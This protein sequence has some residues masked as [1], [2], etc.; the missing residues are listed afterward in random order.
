L[1]EIA[2]VWLAIC[3]V[4][5]MDDT[6]IVDTEQEIDEARDLYVALAD[7]LNCRQNEQ[8]S[9]PP[10]WQKGGAVAGSCLGPCL[11]LPQ[12]NSELD[13]GILCRLHLPE[14]KASKYKDGL[15]KHLGAE[16]LAPGA[17]GK[18]A[19]RF[20]WAASV[21]FGR[22]ARAFLWPVRDR[23]HNGGGTVL[24]S[25]ALRAALLALK[26]FVLNLKGLTLYASEAPRQ[27]VVGFV[28]ASRSH[29]A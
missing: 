22:S 2:N 21:A 8:K 16:E 26:G 28:D 25:P 10:R 23:Q 11:S 1:L 7:L 20:D 9:M 4:V 24:L 17:A 15:N 5:H 19:G 6:V 14:D 12:T 27:T 3:A 18:L 29:T 13:Q